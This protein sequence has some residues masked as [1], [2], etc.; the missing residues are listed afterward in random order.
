M[1][2]TRAAAIADYH[3]LITADLAAADAQ[4]AWLVEQQHA[5]GALFGGRPMATSLRPAFLSEATYR[6]VEATVFTLRRALQALAD[7]YLTDPAVLDELGL[8]ELERELL[9]IPTKVVQLSATTRLDAFMTADSFQF[10]EVNAECPAGLAYCHE[11]A[12]IYRELP[13]FRTFAAFRPVRFVSPLEHLLA[14]LL[15]VYHEEWGG[16]EERPS[17][18]IV[19]FLNIPTYPEFLLIKSYFERHG[20][21]CEIAD[22]RMLECRD[23]WIVA[24]GRRVDVLYRRLLTNE[25]AAIRPEC[26]A[27]LDG[28]RAGRTCFVNSF[29]T[30]F[31][32]KKAV[33]ALLTDPTYASIL[34][35][36]TRGVI[37]AHVPW[38]RRVREQRTEHGGERVDLLPHLRRHR[39]EFVLKPNDEYGGKGVVIG[40]AASPKE[41]DDALDRAL[42]HGDV[43]QELV[44]VHREPFLLRG[45]GGW[46]TV[47][48]IVDLDP[49]LNGSLLGGCLVRISATNLANVTAG[50]GSL[51]MFVLRES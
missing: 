16:A 23:G 36:H 19:D 21:A 5:R 34:D 31:L 18:A 3:R 8:T 48:Q 4:L 41:W 6:A 44:R 37:R 28:Y 39:E 2:E 26:R 14:G 10:V 33:F 24:N 35:D 7:A 45:E 38:T 47:D 30:K 46:E 42:R 25:F 29:R 27:L 22:P 50:G 49:Y 13:L 12:G 1:T 20:C 15:R 43:A 17:F 9:A 51:P 40:F 32:H 11:L